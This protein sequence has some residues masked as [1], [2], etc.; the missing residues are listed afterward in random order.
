MNR[1][2]VTRATHLVVRFF[3][4]LRQAGI[5]P[6]DETWAT[7]QLLAPER[8]LWFA[9]SEADRRHG[10]AVA[11]RVAAALGPQVTRPVVAAALLHDVGKTVSGLGTS[12]RVLATLAIAVAGRTRAESWNRGLRRRIALYSRHPEL[13]ADLLA[14]AGSD[15]LPIA[16]AREDHRPEEAWSIPEDIARVLH[17]ADQE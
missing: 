9:M 13:G 15:P 11:K 10:V 8:E 3:S 5:S 16:W 4:S 12:G 17:A 14:G 7:E 2:P 1:H 6:Q